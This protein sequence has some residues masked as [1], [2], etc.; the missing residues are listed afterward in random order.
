MENKFTVT[1]EGRRRRLPRWVE[2]AWRCDLCGACH[3]WRIA[4]TGCLSIGAGYFPNL[5]TKNGLDIVS[6]VVAFYA[7][8]SARHIDHHVL[9]FDQQIVELIVL[10]QELWENKFIVGSYLQLLTTMTL[11]KSAWLLQME[12]KRE[13]FSR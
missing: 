11:P 13:P 2:Y 12:S 6:Q 8:L 3:V 5:S 10:F 1:E 4:E 9:L 7:L